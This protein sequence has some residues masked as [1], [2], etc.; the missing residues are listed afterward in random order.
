MKLLHLFCRQ[1]GTRPI[2]VTIPKRYVYF[3]EVAHFLS[4]QDGIKIESIDCL[5]LSY[6]TFNLTK[7]IIL[8][9]P[10]VLVCLVRIEN[11]YQT[12][13]LLT[14]IKKLNSNIKVIVY[15]DVVNLINNFFRKIESIDAVVEGGDWELSIIS[16]IDYLNGRVPAAAGVFIKDLGESSPGQY[17]LDGDWYFPD[18]KAIPDSFYAANNNGRNQLTISIARGCPYN[19]KFC[20]SVCTFGSKD[21]RKDV[22]SVL[23]FLEEHKDRFDSFK[24][25]APSFNVDS[26]WVYDFCKGIKNRKLKIAWCATS[27]ID[28]LD[29]EEVVALM[30]R[31]G[32]YKISVGIETINRS[33]KFLNKEFPQEQIIRVA[34]YFQKNKVTL[35]GLIMLG[36]PGQ[37]RE[38]I[39]D[40]F[41]LLRDN[42]IKIRPTSFSPLDELTKG[43]ITLE[44]IQKYD[45]FTFY[46]TGIEGIS[47][48]QYFNLLVDPDNFLDILKN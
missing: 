13:K 34:K 8:E 46:E 10:Q 41:S 37:T 45:K 31:A 43:N 2:H 4:K 21:R 29:N 44:E 17:F 5:D 24:L 20:L 26:K 32:C 42:N 47:R 6:S 18:T 40:L 12:L 33:A 35:K 27:R 30:A 14:H 39:I 23:D 19:C 28:L 16:Y 25:F 36:V 3:W 11:I 48:Q 9:K 38:D 7:K 1:A 15:G 22:N